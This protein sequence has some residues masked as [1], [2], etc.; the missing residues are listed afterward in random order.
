MRRFRCN[1]LRNHWYQSNF[2]LEL[3]LDLEWTL[4]A[5]CDGCLVLE[6]GSE[7]KL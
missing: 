3:S 7:Y 4:G 1:Q 5:A 6:L 2:S